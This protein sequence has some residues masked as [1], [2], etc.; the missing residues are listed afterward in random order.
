MILM[1]LQ[2]LTVM[3][4]IVMQV[5]ADFMSRYLVN[6]P[7]FGFNAIPIPV[8]EAGNI[9]LIFIMAVVNALTIKE[10]S[11]GYWGTFL[12]NLGIMLV[13]SGVT[14]MAAHIFIEFALG[15]MPSL[16]LPI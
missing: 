3:L 10:V 4:L 8:I 12:L 11:G 15:S 13:V 14:W 1:I 7:Y 9:A 6:L 2:P 5:L 16:E